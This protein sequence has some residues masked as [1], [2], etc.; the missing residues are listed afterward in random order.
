M[1]LELVTCVW[2]FRP[3]DAE[4]HKTVVFNK[5]EDARRV[6]ELSSSQ[7]VLACTCEERTGMGNPSRLRLIA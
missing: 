7:T 4:S 6:I 1:F 2:K 5:G 3:A